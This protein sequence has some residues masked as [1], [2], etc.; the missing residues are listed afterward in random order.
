M[1]LAHELGH[2]FHNLVLAEQPGTRREITSALA[3][4]ASTFAEATFRDRVLDG[5]TDPT[6]RAFM[7]DQELQAAVAFLMDIPAR[8]RFERRLFTLRRDGVLD[9]D[10]LSEE[11]VAC[12][13]AA[14]G[15]GLGSYD[16][17]FWCSKLHFYIPEF[18]FYNWPYTFGYLFSAAVYQ[19]AKAQGPSFMDTLRELLL[20]TGWQGSE[21]LAREVLGVDLTDPAFWIGAARPVEQRVEAFLEI[22]S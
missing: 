20:R 16:P 14:Y 8:F 21:D 22:T 4:T 12:Q 2:A 17:L 6:Q 18:G 15:D 1:T 3:E 10:Q 19:R 13:R 7:L 9:P 11:M 5:T